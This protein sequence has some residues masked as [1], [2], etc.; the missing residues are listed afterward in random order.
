MGGWDDPQKFKAVFTGYRIGG[1]GSYQFLH[2]LRDVIYV[3]IFGERI[4]SAEMTGVAFMDTC[5]S[6]R[7]ATGLD[8]LMGYY[9]A[10]RISTTGTPVLISFG[11]NTA[12]EGFVCGVNFQLVDAQS[13]LGQFVMPI[14]FPPRR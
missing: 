13:G 11:I 1:Q 4:G 12:I 14:H 3:Y 9:E 6:D 2:T 10:N 7:I 8:D 5:I